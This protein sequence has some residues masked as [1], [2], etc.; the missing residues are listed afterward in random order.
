M[1]VPFFILRPFLKFYIHIYKIKLDDFD[2]DIRKVKTFNEFF[3]RKLKSGA[4]DF[5]G[6]LIS[7]SD[8]IITD[9]GLLS[10]NNNTFEIKGMDCEY[11]SLMNSIQDVH[12]KSFA[13]FYLSPADYHRFHSP[14]DFKVDNISY[15]PGK[16]HSVKPKRT[17]KYSD[18]YCLNRRM[19]LKGKTKFGRATIIL[20]GAMV[21]GKI[22][23]PAF[24][25]K[26]RKR[27]QTMDLDIEF[28]AGEEIGYFELGST[29]ILLME[30]DE[31]N[32]INFN[33]NDHV[34]VGQNL[35]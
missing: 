21:V 16:L 12:M 15:I 9:F 23:L 4:R 8:S 20:V 1:K 19:I 7:P 6:E 29:I 11:E 22:V 30:N 17:D 27:F 10:G 33:K 31:L 3:V 26:K 35:F 2:I 34:N 32:R 14:F 13:I 18:L 25:L 28:K 24:K 5:N